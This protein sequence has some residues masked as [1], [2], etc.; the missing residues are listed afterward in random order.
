MESNKIHLVNKTAYAGGSMKICQ[1]DANSLQLGSFWTV[2][3]AVTL[4][5]NLFAVFGNVIVICACYLHKKQTPFI[6]YISALGFSDLM[7]ALSAPWY[8]YR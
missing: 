3:F 5:L 4:C 1:Y 2:L 6:I 8:S 7:Y